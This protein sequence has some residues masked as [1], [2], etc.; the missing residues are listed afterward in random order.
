MLYLPTGAF[1]PMRVQGCFLSDEEVNRIVKYHSWH[2][3]PS[4]YDPDIWKKW[5]RS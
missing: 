1:A 3:N 5:K 4:T 2:T